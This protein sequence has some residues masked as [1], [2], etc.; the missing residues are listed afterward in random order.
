M[1]RPPLSEKNGEAIRFCDFGGRSAL[2]ALAGRAAFFST[3]FTLGAI[4]TFAGRAFAFRTSRAR[5]H[6]IGTRNDEKCDE[7]GEEEQKCFHRIGVVR[8][9][10]LKNDDQFAISFFSAERLFFK[11]ITIQQ[12][13]A[14]ASTH[15]GPSQ[16]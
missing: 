8:I 3:G 11:R 7:C 10:T 15:H 2:A 13:M 9:N 14:D 12:P 6:G 4:F 16:P 5:L 1:V